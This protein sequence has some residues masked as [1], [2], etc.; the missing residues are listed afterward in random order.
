MSRRTCSARDNLRASLREYWELEDRTETLPEVIDDQS[1]LDAGWELHFIADFYQLYSLAYPPVLAVKPKVAP[2]GSIRISVSVLPEEKRY[3]VFRDRLRKALPFFATIRVEAPILISPYKLEL[4]AA[5]NSQ[6]EA[7][8]KRRVR[9]VVCSPDSQAEVERIVKDWKEQVESLR[10]EDK[11]A[12]SLQDAADRGERFSLLTQLGFYAL[13][14]A[15]AAGN[16]VLSFLLSDRDPKPHVRD[17]PGE[18]QELL[19]SLNLEPWLEALGSIRREKRLANIVDASAIS[20][21]VKLNETAKRENRTDVYFLLSDASTLRTVLG[22]PYIKKPE[23]P[24]GMPP[25]CCISDERFRKSGCRRTRTSIL[26][27]SK[28][29]EEFARAFDEDRHRRRENLFRR[30]ISLL[31]RVRP[32]S[33]QVRDV[34]RLCPWGRFGRCTEDIATRCKD[35]RASIRAFLRT[36]EGLSN[37]ETIISKHAA[38]KPLLA[39]MNKYLLNAEY[40]PRSIMTLDKSFFAFFKDEYEPAVLKD[41]HSALERYSHDTYRHFAE[42]ARKS[43]DIAEDPTASIWYRLRR[44]RGLVFDVAFRDNERILALTRRVQ[45][46]ETNDGNRLAHLKEWYREMVLVITEK[47]DD[48][49]AALLNAIVLYCY[50]YYDD[51]SWLA[52]LWLRRSRGRDASDSLK[53]LETEFFYMN[54]SAEARKAFGIENP[55]AA[56][57]SIL[58]VVTR[59]DAYMKERR[60]GSDPRLPYLAGKILGR[61]HQFDKEPGDTVLTRSLE[62][63]EAALRVVQCSSTQEYATLLLSLLNNKLYVLVRLSDPTPD[64]LAEADRLYGYLERTSEAGHGNFIETF[65]SYMYMRARHAPS[66]RARKELLKE[67]INL[68]RHAN[69]RA[70]E[71]YINRQEQGVYR[72]QLNLWNREYTRAYGD[73]TT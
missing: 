6:L 3:A 35:T 1:L 36:E 68:L 16:D 43:I 33:T 53:E 70:R 25:P 11:S 28:H 12:E 46:P 59:I 22:R 64:Q 62:Y 39:F 9:D 65:A 27:T 63:T 14:L 47:Q 54:M 2:D 15:S 73:P 48:P 44:M 17:L 38:F 60:P 13:T 52:A 5:L 42:V 72:K 50:D 37:L 66:I 32:I 67:A 8:I 34:M 30:K 41:L 29:F 55:A 7:A 23:G 51:C 21:V 10:R 56:K 71:Q 18:S 24:S 4:T 45:N 19:S 61:Q 58:A 20:M 40:T 31:Q 26:R 49:H 69:K 57:S